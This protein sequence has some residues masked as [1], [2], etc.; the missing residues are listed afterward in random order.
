MKM[1]IIIKMIMPP[2]HSGCILMMIMVIMMIMMMMMNM[3]VKTK[4]AITQTI[5]ELGSSD[6]A[7]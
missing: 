1:M 2:V 7:W 4:M 5:F 6:F 3:M